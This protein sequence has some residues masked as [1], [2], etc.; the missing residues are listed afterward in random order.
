MDDFRYTKN[1]I[2]LEH[3]FGSL[4]R[5]KL[6]RLFYGNPERAYFVR[7]LS[8]T[9]EIQLNAVRRELAN[10]EEIGIIKQTEFGQSKD[11]EV[12]TE[13]SKYYKINT[14]FFLHEELGAL[15]EKTQLLE[16][17]NFI[18]L[19]KKRAGSIKVM[20]LTGFFTN[21][22]DV[23][24]DILFV[25]EIKSIAVAKVMKDFEKFL[26]HPVRYTILDEKEFSER[27]EIGDRFLYSIFEGKH[28]FAVDELKIS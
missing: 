12:G 7:E 9:I 15:L 16:E 22:P 14:G 23:G 26:N 2:M 8:R 1:E 20:I 5:I 13:R 25:G 27:R 10:L 19:L 6:L 4:T 24:T 21:T 28:I 17:R 18:D 3:L 11:E